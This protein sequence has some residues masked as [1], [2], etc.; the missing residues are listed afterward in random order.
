[1][2]RIVDGLCEFYV[3]RVIF[4][5]LYSRGYFIQVAAPAKR[6]SRKVVEAH[7]RAHYGPAAVLPDFDNPAVLWHCASRLRDISYF[8]K[9]MQQA[10]TGWINRVKFAGKRQ[11]PAWCSRFKS[12]IL[13]PAYHIFTKAAALADLGQPRLNRAR[14]ATGGRAGQVPR[15][16]LDRHPVLVEMLEDAAKLGVALCIFFATRRLYPLQRL[17]MK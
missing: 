5:Q 15:R 10:F 9:D 6:P 1:M 11:G 16:F 13:G 8:L 12:K 4:F 17:L 3:V 14:L 2:R 7:Y